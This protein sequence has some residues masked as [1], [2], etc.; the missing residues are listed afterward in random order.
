V[1]SWSTAFSGWGILVHGGAGRVPEERRDAHAAG[2]RRAAE[3]AA[4]LLGAGG[5]A[6]DAAQCAVEALEDDPS[7]NAGTGGSLTSEA[8]LEF[9]AAVMDG[10]DLGAGAV[11]ALPPFEH[12][13]AV[14]RA[15]LAEGQYV[16]YAGEGAARLAE[17]A[18]FARADEAAMITEAARGR[19][20]RARAAGA[21]QHWA[22]DT[23]GAVAADA[24]GN[25]AAATSTGGSVGKHPGRVGDSPIIGV[26]TY[27]DNAAG[28]ASATGNGEAIMRVALCSRTLELLRAGGEPEAVVCRAI[29]E[30]KQRVGGSGGLILLAPGG[31]MALA[32]NT[33]T[34]SWAAHWPDGADSGS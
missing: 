10:S 22:G 21:A 4:E 31:R 1:H 23:V 9:D 32:R 6:L 7:F 8:H 17:R 11:C 30:M 13:V 5:S 14:A 12:P 25:L 3:R 28:A 2:C 15:V 34:M 33:P 16:M 18:G 29:A 26:G 20:Q 19:L 27:A 24:A